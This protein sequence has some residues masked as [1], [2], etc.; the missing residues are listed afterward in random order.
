VTV[1]DAAVHAVI[2]S[3]DE[4]TWKRITPEQVAA[5]DARMGE[6]FRDCSV[7]VVDVISER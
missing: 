5:V 2:W 7:Q 6:W 1:N 3:T 4:P